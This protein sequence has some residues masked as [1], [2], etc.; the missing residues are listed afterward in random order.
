MAIGTVD[1]AEVQS[2]LSVPQSAP[3]SRLEWRKG[4][5]MSAFPPAG[6]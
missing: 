2:G 1:S 5:G 3:N 4:S 6:S